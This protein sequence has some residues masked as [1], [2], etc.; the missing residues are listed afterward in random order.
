VT[1][2]GLLEHLR[3]SHR[4]LLAGRTAWAETRMLLNR[5]TALA[6]VSD[7]PSAMRERL[8]QL[9]E[10][11]EPTRRAHVGSGQHFAR[12][13]RATETLLAAIG[14]RDDQGRS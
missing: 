8:R 14:Q 4:E 2:P 13:L 5:I 9:G 12:A 3:S 7:D 1:G 6:H 11:A 10:L